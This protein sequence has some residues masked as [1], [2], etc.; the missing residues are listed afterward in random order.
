MHN[1]IFRFFFYSF[2]LFGFDIIRCSVFP[3]FLV[4]IFDGLRPLLLANH[5][6]IC[7]LANKLRSFVRYL[8]KIRAVKEMFDEAD[9]LP[10]NRIL[11]NNNIVPQ[12]DLT[13]QERLSSKY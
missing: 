4:A 12:S 9:A 6:Q 2:C 13:E 11:E 3:I 7:S 5:F 8:K 1:N 10:F